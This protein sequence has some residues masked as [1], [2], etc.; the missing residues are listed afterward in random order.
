MWCAYVHV[1]CFQ[2]WIMGCCARICFLWKLF[3]YCLNIKAVRVQETCFVLKTY[4]LIPKILQ[5]HIHLMSLYLSPSVMHSCPFLYQNINQ[6]H[7]DQL[8]QK[9]QSGV[10]VY[11][12]SF[13]QNWINQVG[14]DWFLIS[15]QNVWKEVKLHMLFMGTRL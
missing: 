1:F 3:G 6:T 7:L 13:S 4:K 15:A 8:G 14:M 9:V 2:P 5:K 10:F 12:G 11:N